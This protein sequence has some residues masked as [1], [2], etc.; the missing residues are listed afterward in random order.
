MDTFGFDF[1]LKR[2][3]ERFTRD[4]T[5]A[6]LRDELPPVRCRDAAINR[7]I[8][9][10]VRQSKNN[11]VL[12]GE[13]GVGKTAVAEG[14]AQWIVAGDVPDSLQTARVLSVSHMDLIA[15]TSFRGQ[16]ERRLQAL[17]KEASADRNIILFID[18]L[19]NLIGAGT[20]IGAPMDAA[21]L[22]KPA[23]AG[24]SLRVIGATTEFEY[25]QYIRAD[26]ALERRFQPVQ[27]HELN[28]QET[29]EVLLA[30]RPLLEMHHLLSIGDDTL[31]AA[32]DVSL[33]YAPSRKQPDRSIDLLDETCA[34]IRLRR[35]QSVSPKILAWNE[36]REVLRA[37]EKELIDRITELENGEGNF[38]ERFSR[39]TYRAFESAGLKLESMI[40]GKRTPRRP[41]PPP[42]SHR[43]LLRADPAK[44]LARIHCERLKIEDK[45]RKAL[46]RHGAI[47]TPADI[48]ETSG[49]AGGIVMK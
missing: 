38:V 23:L 6:A 48:H 25:D 14:L 39:G 11:P 35:Q 5:A 28:A 20:A 9:V 16:Y 17:V 40:T 13:A 42:D 18:E 10:L 3:L 21:N 8:T 36:K 45:L 29:L 4:L 27:I 22:L 19:H 49:N 41:L 33:Q 30:R 1:S 2:P 43:K 47:V 7:V 46:E 31:K 44:D 12:V 32:I 34:S 24:G 26:S 15:G 37:T